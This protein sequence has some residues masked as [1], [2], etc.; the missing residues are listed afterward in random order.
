MIYW[1]FYK[2]KDEEILKFLTGL[3]TTKCSFENDNGN[4]PYVQRYVLYFADVKIVF[5]SHSS[6]NR[7]A[8][9]M[10]RGATTI[11]NV[12]MCYYKSYKYIYDRM[13]KVQEKRLLVEKIKEKYASMSSM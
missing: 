9:I 11:Y 13:F 7:E 12:P 1:L 10:D 8:V 3:F 6:G 5:W 2:K 4:S